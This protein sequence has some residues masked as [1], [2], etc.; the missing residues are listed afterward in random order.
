MYVCMYVRT[1][2]YQ[3]EGWFGSS[4]SAG[5]RCARARTHTHT[6][7]PMHSTPHTTI[8][9]RT[10]PGVKWGRVASSFPPPYCTQP[11]NDEGHYLAKICNINLIY[12]HHPQAKNNNESAC[13]LVVGLRIL[14]PIY[15]NIFFRRSVLYTGNILNNFCRI[16]TMVCWY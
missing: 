2:S 13:I 10:N 15:F 6:H 9:R 3:P 8:A 1:Y 14:I 12:L 11:G 16:L 4:Y 7:M 5:T